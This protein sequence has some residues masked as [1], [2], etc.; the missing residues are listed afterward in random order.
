LVVPSDVLRDAAALTPVDRPSDA[1]VESEPT[2]LF[3]EER[4]VE[5]EAAPL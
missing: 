5:S 1:D 2:L 4:P 3:V